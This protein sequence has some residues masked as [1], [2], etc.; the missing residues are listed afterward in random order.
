MNRSLVATVAFA[1]VCILRPAP[2]MAQ[3]EEVK[4]GVKGLTCN[5]CAAGL[6]RSLRRLEGVSSVEIV[7][8][9]EAA[10]V[11]LKSGASFDPEKFRVA[12]KNA[13]QEARNFE[14]RLSAAVQREGGRYT[15]QPGGG[16][17]LPVRSTSATKLEPFVG[18]IVRARAKVFSSP[19]SPLELELTDVAIQ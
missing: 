7:V 13:G 19:Q 16:T 9:E 12:V 10:N 4:I 17:A 5:L 18:R 11:R 3:I 2:L 8:A 6:E 1:A 15:L 14:L